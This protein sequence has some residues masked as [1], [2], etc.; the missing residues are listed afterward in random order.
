MKSKER[1]SE[2]RDVELT[3]VGKFFRDFQVGQ[4]H[5]VVFKEVLED[6]VEKIDQSGGLADGVEVGV[7]AV[8][9]GISGVC[10]QKKYLA[11][12]GI[13]GRVYER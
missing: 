7:H 5:L 9:V 11:K 10:G 2:I 4:V 6:S 13:S 3:F 1:T 12:R 8:R